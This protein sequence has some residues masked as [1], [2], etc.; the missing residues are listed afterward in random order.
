MFSFYAILLFIS[1]CG[2]IYQINKDDCAV[3]PSCSAKVVSKINIEEVAKNNRL[4]CVEVIR[5]NCPY[6]SL[7]ADEFAALKAQFPDCVFV[8]LNQSH[9][10]V[11]VKAVRGKYQIATVPAFIVF[12]G[13]VATV[14]VGSDKLAEV[15][16]TLLAAKNSIDCGNQ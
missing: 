2:L 15:K 16:K 11:Y 8:Q 9:D 10:E 7:I 3:C 13:G 14:V 12:C 6:C 1:I 4:V 5:D